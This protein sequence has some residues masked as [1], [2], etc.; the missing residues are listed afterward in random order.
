[1]SNNKPIPQIGPYRKVSP[2]WR[3]VRSIGDALKDTIKHFRL[4]KPYLEA[5]IID[6]YHKVMGPAISHKTEMVFLRGK[7][8][9]LKITDAA[10]RHHLYLNQEKLLEVLNERVG[11][12]VATSVVMI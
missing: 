5:G 1:M 9:Y 12:V 6:A 4:E 2:R 8:L 3:E 11:Q 7:T 10:L